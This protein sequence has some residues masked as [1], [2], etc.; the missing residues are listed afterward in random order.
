MSCGDSAKEITRHRSNFSQ[1][2]RHWL[3]PLRSVSLG[4]HRH[5]VN[6]EK[7]KQSWLNDILKITEL[8]EQ[9]VQY[10]K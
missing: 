6:E 9:R 1:Y 3:L 8:D 4:K 10:T 7:V 5:K 2:V